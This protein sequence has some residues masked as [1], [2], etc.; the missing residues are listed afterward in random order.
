[1][2]KFKEGDF[3]RII[4][5]EGVPAMYRG[6]L[7]YVNAVINFKAERMQMLRINTVCGE[8]VLF[9]FEVKPVEEGRE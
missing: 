1:M 9:D 5:G 2:T 8:I 3:V 7:G 6:L 4:P